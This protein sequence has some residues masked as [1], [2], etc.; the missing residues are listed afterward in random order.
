MSPRF[1][2]LR[3]GGRGNERVGYK[4]ISSAE[5]WHDGDYGQSAHL[6]TFF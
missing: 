5:R 1:S 4:R 2:F 6:Q 3:Y